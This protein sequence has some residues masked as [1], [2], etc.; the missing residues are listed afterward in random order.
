[1]ILE[2]DVNRR[3]WNADAA[4][5]TIADAR[6]TTVTVTAVT[7]AA[8][9]PT[10]AAGDRGLHRKRNGGPK[11]AKMSEYE[12]SERGA[13]EKEMQKRMV[14]RVTRAGNIAVCPANQ[15]VRCA[16]MRR[17]RFRGR[18]FEK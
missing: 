6:V 14:G 3:R 13:S 8:T 4:H 1:M 7:S 10:T 16:L 9:M 11:R 17:I 5:C 15:C 18:K 12:Q 2:V